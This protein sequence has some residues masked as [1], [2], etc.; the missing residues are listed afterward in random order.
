VLYRTD[1]APVTK[2]AAIAAIEHEKS[3]NV[4]ASVSAIESMR[5][6]VYGDGAAMIANYAS[7]DKARPPYRAA[8]VWAKRNGQWQLV[9]EVETDLKG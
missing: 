2:A 6:S 9:I 5:L 8:S 4:G 7:P 3:S 1:R